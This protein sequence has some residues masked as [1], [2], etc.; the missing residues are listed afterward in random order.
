ML[1]KR[2][3]IEVHIFALNYRNNKISISSA[4]STLLC[5]KLQMSFSALEVDNSRNQN[6]LS[7]YL[8][9]GYTFMP[10]HLVQQTV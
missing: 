3:S 4:K 1:L 5:I 2:V 6:V 8:L 10:L 7:K 9:L